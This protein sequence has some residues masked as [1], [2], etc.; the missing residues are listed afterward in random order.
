M[1]TDQSK[2]KAAANTKTTKT[3]SEQKQ[4]RRKVLRNTLIGG[5][6]ISAGAIPEKW[7]K[8][9]LEAVILPAHAATTDDTGSGSGGIT[10]AA[11]V[12]STTSAP[13]VTTTCNPDSPDWNPNTNT[14]IT[15]NF[16][17]WTDPIA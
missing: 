3:G 15:F 6:V 8:P 7:R 12:T 17:S 5:A 10:T 4:A 13:I 14:C 9:A 16:S 11:P 2:S 1:D